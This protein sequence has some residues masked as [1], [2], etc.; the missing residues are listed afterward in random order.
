MNK[1]TVAGIHHVTA[2]SGESQRNVD[3]YAGVLGLR[4]VKRTVNFDDPGTYH[5]YYGDRTGSPGTILTFFPWAGLPRGRAGTGQVT[6]TSLAI[7]RAALGFWTARLVAHG[8]SL[9]G[10]MERFGAPVLTFADPD[11]MPLELVADEAASSA[12]AAWHGAPVVAEHAVRGVHSAAVS[13]TSWEATAALLTE[14]FGFRPAGEEHGRFRFTSGAAVGAHLD[15]LPQPHAPPA[16]TAVGSVH[17]IA[18]RCANDA[19]QHAWRRL[20]VEKGYDVSPTMDRGYFRSIYFREPGGVLFEVATDVPGFAAD[21]PVEALGSALKLPAWLENRRLQIEA[22]LPALHLPEL[23][24]VPA[25]AAA[26]A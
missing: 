17:H 13:L 9:S 18:F 12:A 24:S 16:R 10:P 21:E 15:L 1:P 7:P 6:A 5:L 14:L 3:F 23:E 11:G 2:I 22:R 26:V 4:L 19:E 8:I 20:L 25:P